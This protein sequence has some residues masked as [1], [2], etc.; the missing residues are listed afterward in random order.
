MGVRVRVRVRVR[1]RVRA[2]VRG[3][4]RVRVRARDRDRVR[5]RVRDRVR[6]RVRGG[7][8][9]LGPKVISPTS[10]PSPSSLLQAQHWPSLKVQQAEPIALHSD[11]LNP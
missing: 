7:P 2:R 9:P 4:A 6:A 3:R 8:S 1:A 10:P 11:S 5:V